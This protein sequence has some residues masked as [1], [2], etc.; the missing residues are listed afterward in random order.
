MILPLLLLLGCQLAGE[1][2]SRGF[3]LPL[4]GPVLGM[5]LIL[6]LFVALPRSVDLMR[7][8]IVVLL[9]NLSLM[10]IPAG[11][12]IVAFLGEL[13]HDGLALAVTLIGSTTA[14]LVAGAWAFLIVAR[15]TGNKAPE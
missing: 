10:F 14:A 2:L 15:L 1:V 9:A 13:R 4:P 8:V 3:Q 6:A 5:V 12:G 11:A 7:P